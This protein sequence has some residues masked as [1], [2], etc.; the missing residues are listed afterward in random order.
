MGAATVFP[1]GIHCSAPQEDCPQMWQEMAA[2]ALITVTV[3]MVT[4]T[5]HLPCP[6]TVL[7]NFTHS[8]SFKL[9]NNF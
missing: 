8:N 7:S 6:S 2:A 9:H 4:S 1:L 3:K 5:Q